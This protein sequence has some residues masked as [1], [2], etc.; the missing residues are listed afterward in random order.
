LRRASARGANKI[1]PHLRGLSSLLLGRSPVSHLN[2]GRRR[3]LL[4][5]GLHLPVILLPRSSPPRPAG[6]RRTERAKAK[7]RGKKQTLGL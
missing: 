1:D 7:T 4:L 5:S 6:E 2:I 3:P